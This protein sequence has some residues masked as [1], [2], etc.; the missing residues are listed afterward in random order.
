MGLRI[1]GDGDGGVNNVEVDSLKR[2]SVLATTQTVDAAINARTEKVWSAPFKDLSPTG[3]NDYVFYI[4]NNGDVTLCITD[5]RITSKVAGTEVQINEVTGT[6]SGG[7]DSAV[8][9]RTVGSAQVPTATVQSGADITG[10]A[11]AG[12]IFDI[13]C[14][15]VGQQEHLRTTS[16][17][18]LKKG[19]AIALLCEVATAELTGTISIVEDC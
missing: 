18:R 13:Q 10:L 19:Q 14:N 9:S 16:K 8:I 12:T 4:K 1:E 11:S 3:A 17:I 2:M 5:V 15:T 6:A 7:S